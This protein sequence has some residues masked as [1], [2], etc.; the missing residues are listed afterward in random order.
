[1]T[2]K[3]EP[4]KKYEQLAK[5][6]LLKSLVLATKLFENL[7][8]LS[9]ARKVARTV[10]F[11]PLKSAISTLSLRNGRLKPGVPG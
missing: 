4:H 9:I 6:L 7:P 8:L 10:S 2:K 11:A 1:M 5:Q 3:T